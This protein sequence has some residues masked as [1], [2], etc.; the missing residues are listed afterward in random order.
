MAKIGNFK[1]VSGEL[2][3]QITS[4]NFSAFSPFHTFPAG[5]EDGNH[6]GPAVALLKTSARSPY[7][8]NFH[9]ADLGH[10]MVIGPSGGGK[11]VLV[12][13]LMA[14]LEK[15]NARHIFIDKDQGAEI[16]VRASGG[17]YLELRNG[18]PTGFAPLK[19]LDN[20]ASNRAFLGSFNRQ[21]GRAHTSELQSLM[22]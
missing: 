1:M 14:Q 16:F 11:T 7:Y 8:F 9:S 15:F 5:H 2:R 3:G 12:N 4:Y 10:S 20:T 17:T 19:A 18:E 13:F 6:W 21:N 22:R